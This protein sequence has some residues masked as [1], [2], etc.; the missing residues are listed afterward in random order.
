M[1]SQRMTVIAADNGN[2]HCIVRLRRTCGNASAVT[3]LNI[4]ELPGCI[5]RFPGLRELRGSHVVVGNLG[6]QANAK[7]RVRW[8][9]SWQAG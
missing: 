9:G 1:T 8:I 2:L 5:R 3:L 7:L 4:I 6:E